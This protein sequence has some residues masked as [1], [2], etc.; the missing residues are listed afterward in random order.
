MLVE[1]YVEAEELETDALLGWAI[2]A[3]G[4]GQFGLSGED[5]LYYYLVDLLLE[6]VDILA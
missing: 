5:G 2:R 1:H 3:V 6:L 4:M